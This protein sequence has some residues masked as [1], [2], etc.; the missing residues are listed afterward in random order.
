MQAANQRRAGTLSACNP[1]R[2]IRQ[3]DKEEKLQ[4]KKSILPRMRALPL[5]K[6]PFFELLYLR[7]FLRFKKKVSFSNKLEG[8]GGK[9]NLTRIKWKIA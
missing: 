2:E 5:R 9:K 7:N 3:L 1:R 4:Q 8:G 6:R